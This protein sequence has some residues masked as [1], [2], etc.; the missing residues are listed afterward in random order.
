MRFRNLFYVGLVI[1]SVVSCKEEDNTPVEYPD[2]RNTNEAAFT[3][4]Y[5]D[6]KTAIESGSTEWMLL[7]SVMKPDSLVTELAPENYV[8]VKVLEEGDDT[9]SPYQTDS[10]CVHYRGRLLPSLHYPTGRVF[11]KSYYGEY[12]DGVS[13]PYRTVVGGIEGFSTVL[14]YMHRG[15]QWEVSIPYQLAYGTKD[16][17]SIPAYSMLIFEIRLDDF[18]S[19]EEGDRY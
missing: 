3:K 11:D 7:P 15:D 6:A 13:N 18:W 5:Y 17:E 4:L 14:Q 19:K 10:V 12:V 16:Y 8:V 1:L 2:W 9:I